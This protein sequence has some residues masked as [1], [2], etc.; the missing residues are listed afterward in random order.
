[1]GA[2]PRRQFELNRYRRGGLVELYAYPVTSDAY[3][4]R[5]GLDTN[6]LRALRQS[7][8]SFR[9]QQDKK[10]LSKL[11]QYVPIEGFNPITDDDFND[12]RS[13]MRKEIAEFERGAPNQDPVAPPA[14]A[15]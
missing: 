1:M 5:P 4:S 11:T 2:A 12:I 7:L 14:Q 3:I 13:A 8:A 6:V 9:S 15:R 10:I